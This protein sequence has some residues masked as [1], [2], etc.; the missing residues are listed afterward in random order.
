MNA[1]QLQFLA[2]VLVN[3]NDAGADWQ[4]IATQ[5]AISRKDNAQSSFKNIIQKIGLKYDGK[6]FT[7]IVD[8]DSTKLVTSTPK[9]TATPRKRKGGA[10]ADAGTS[11]PTKKRATKKSKAVEEE[12]DSE[13][14]LKPGKAENGTEES[15]EN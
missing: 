4:E 5:R 3:L 11:S 12:D 7:Q 6:K 8:F 10:D 13:S 15:S 14:D 1:D 9:K 2:T